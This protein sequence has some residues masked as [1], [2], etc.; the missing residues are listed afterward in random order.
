MINVQINL[1][2]EIIPQ[3]VEKQKEAGEFGFF[4]FHL[5]IKNT[6]KVTWTMFP[7]L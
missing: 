6:I 1:K 5:S 4:L 3:I 7:L 2:I